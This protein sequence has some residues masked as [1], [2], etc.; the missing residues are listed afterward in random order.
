MSQQTVLDAGVQLSDL[1][2]LSP[3]CCLYLCIQRSTDRQH[4]RNTAENDQ[5]QCKTGLRKNQKRYQNLNACNK[6]FL[7]AVMRKF[8]HV[9]QVIGNPP[10]NLP[11]LGIVIIGIGQFLQMMIRCPSHIRLYMG[12]HYMSGVRHVKIGQTVH[13]PQCKIQ[14]RQLQ[15]QLRCQRCRI[16]APRIGNI[17]DDQRKHHLADRRQGRTA[18]VLQQNRK[19]RSVIRK[20]TF[21][22]FFAFIFSLIHLFLCLLLFR[23]FLHCTTQ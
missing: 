18:Q 21:Q 23:I 2:P 10:H 17:A 6:K 11:D 8:R 9:K 3:K 12:T 19:I 14:G 16:A 22:K 13:N 5:R 15:N 1:L 4:Q 20:K 7:R